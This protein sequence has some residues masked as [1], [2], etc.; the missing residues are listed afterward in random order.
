MKEHW[1]FEGGALV[2]T[3]A[4]TGSGFRIM[5]IRYLFC[6]EIGDAEEPRGDAGQPVRHSSAPDATSSI[7]L[8]ALSH[9]H[10]ALDPD[11][12]P[13][14]MEGRN[15]LLWAVERQADGG[16][17]LTVFEGGRAA[18]VTLTRGQPMALAREL[19]DGG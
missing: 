18:T 4:A 14:A 8:D 7:D 11:E 17:S 19:R 16:T 15:G 5:P 3:G 1:E 10:A 2:L 12:S 6:D 9:T 13:E